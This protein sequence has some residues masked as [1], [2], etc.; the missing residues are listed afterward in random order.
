MNSLFGAS[1]LYSEL[2][3]YLRSVFGNNWNQVLG[4]LIVLFMIYLVFSVIVF[5]IS[6]VGDFF[7]FKKVGEAPHKC[8]IP[9]YSEYMSYNYAGIPL[10]YFVVLVLSIVYLVYSLIVGSESDLFNTVSIVYSVVVLI[11]QAYKCYRVSKHFGHGIGW[12]LGLFFL[13]PF[14]KLALGVGKSEYNENAI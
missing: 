4:V 8:F 1:V 14:F 12:A 10:W 7:I 9:C 3:S 5:I 6:K 11:I 13:W 2:E